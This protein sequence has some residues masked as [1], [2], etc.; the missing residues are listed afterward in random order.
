MTKRMDSRFHGNDRENMRFACRTRM[1]KVRCGITNLFRHCQKQS[2]EAIIPLFVI[3]RTASEAWQDEAI[4][5]SKKYN[6]EKSN[7]SKSATLS[8]LH[9]RSFPSFPPRVVAFRRKL[10]GMRESKKTRKHI[11]SL[12]ADKVSAAIQKNKNNTQKSKLPTLNSIYFMFH[13]ASRIWIA[14][15]RSQ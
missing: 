1:I 2:H 4:Q 5:K 14:T 10:I 9:K 8:F 15:L 12:R 7:N 13:N 3:A 6:H 11:S